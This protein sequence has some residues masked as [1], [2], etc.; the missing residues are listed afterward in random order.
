MRRGTTKAPALEVKMSVFLLD[1]VSLVKGSQQ[2]KKIFIIDLLSLENP[3]SVILLSQQMAIQK[4]CWDTGNAGFSI[5]IIFHQISW[6]LWKD[7]EGYIFLWKSRQLVIIKWRNLWQKKVWGRKTKPS[8]LPNFQF[9]NG[10]PGFFV[11]I[12][13]VLAKK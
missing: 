4:T 13:T 12:S 8:I 9:L 10:H 11:K 5:I 3:C 1:Q 7:N 2:R 6:I